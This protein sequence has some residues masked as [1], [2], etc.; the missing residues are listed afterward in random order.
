MAEQRLQTARRP[1][2]FERDEGDR[3]AES[4]GRVLD[5]E[6]ETVPDCETR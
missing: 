2:D 5:F 6:G 4:E 3:E 1:L